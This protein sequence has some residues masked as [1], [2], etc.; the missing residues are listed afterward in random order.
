MG[1]KNKPNRWI[2][3]LLFLIIILFGAITVY[4]STD[5]RLTSTITLGVLFIAFGVAINIYSKNRIS[6]FKWPLILLSSLSVI[7]LVIYRI[8]LP[9]VWDN[10]WE[11][12]EVFFLFASANIFLAAIFMMLQVFLDRQSSF[13][14][15]ADSIIIVIP[16][17]LLFWLELNLAE[18]YIH[19]S[20]V[21]DIDRLVYHVE[22]NTHAISQLLEKNSEDD[23]FYK[24]YSLINRANNELLEKSGGMTILGTAVNAT[25]IRYADEVIVK[26][27]LLSD[28]RIK[29]KQLSQLPN[30]EKY[31]EELNTL[32]R[33][34]I[35]SGAKGN[36]VTEMRLRLRLIEQSIKIIELKQ[37]KSW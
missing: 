12:S 14:V 23:P 29:I 18:D 26:S 6:K 20:K 37:K 27:G 9:R 32:I 2:G 5:S 1:L 30:M 21:Q 7:C 19:Q 34:K 8:I 35:D 3:K 25:D 36:S 10:Y 33:Y 15:T 31:R 13:R 24:L 4:F 16:I 11:I 17:F 22:N 28:I